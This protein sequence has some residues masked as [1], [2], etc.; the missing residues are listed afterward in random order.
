M[1]PITSS[2]R[3]LERIHR[4]GGLIAEEC[5]PNHDTLTMYRLTYQNFIKQVA[6]YS[7]GSCIF[8]ITDAGVAE[9]ERH[10]RRT[11]H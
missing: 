2:C 6:T 4:Q 8:A 10:N 5:L 1:D 3:V 7:D 11:G 9:L